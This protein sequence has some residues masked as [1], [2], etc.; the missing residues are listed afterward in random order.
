MQ[1]LGIQGFP[2]IGDEHSTLPVPKEKWFEYGG[3][4][5]GRFQVTSRNARGKEGREDERG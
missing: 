3:E 2:S 1:A 4:R 5:S